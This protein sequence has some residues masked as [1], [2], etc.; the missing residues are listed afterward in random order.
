MPVYAD[1]GN[2]PNTHSAI[3]TA[4]AEMTGNTTPRFGSFSNVSSRDV[5][6]DNNSFFSSNALVMITFDTTRRATLT[7]DVT[8]RPRLGAFRDTNVTRALLGTPSPA[9][10]RV[11]AN[12]HVAIADKSD[13][14]AD[15]A[16]SLRPKRPK[17]IN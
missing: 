14:G 16:T 10:T 5:D 4:D 7:W 2:G 3:N 12:L 9:P 6:T 17:D 8:P 13:E 15:N 1:L 11:G